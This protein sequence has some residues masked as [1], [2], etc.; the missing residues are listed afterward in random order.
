MLKNSELLLAASVPLLWGIGFTFAKAGLNEF[1]PLFLMGLRFT[2][3]AL[4]LVWF[5]PIPRGQLKQIFWISLV[6][7]TLQ[8]GMTFTGLSMLDAS[9]AIIIIHLEVPFSVLLAAIVLKD[10]PGIQRILG[11]LISFAGIVLIAGQPSL[12]KQLPAI[13][14][15]AAGAMTWAVGQ[16]MVKRLENPPSGFALTAWIGVFS[17]PQMI[18]GSFIFEDSQLESLSNASWIGWGVILYLAL[19]MTVLGYG[20]WYHV[21][22]RNHVSKVMPVMLLLPVFTIA[23][24]MLFLGEEPSPMIFIGA[25]VVIGGVSMIVITKDSKLTS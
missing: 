3:A 19:I 2:L 25:A 13:L 6:G 17:G 4:T 8:Y 10:K 7:S 18:L 21:L 15:T 24:S 5:V 23:S 12:S 1:P 9:L 14:L 11:M 22:S 16:I 20:I